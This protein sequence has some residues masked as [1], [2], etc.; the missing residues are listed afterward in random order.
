[1]KE[2][3]SIKNR[4]TGVIIAEGEYDSLADLASATRAKLYGANLT[5]ANLTE[6]AGAKAGS[7]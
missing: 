4:Y 6:G 7:G 1:M 5:G 3:R 2:K